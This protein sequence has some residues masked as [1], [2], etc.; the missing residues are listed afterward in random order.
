MTPKLLQKIKDITV[1]NTE[2]DD[3]EILYQLK[4]IIRAEY[5]HRSTASMPISELISRK[6]KKRFSRF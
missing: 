1:C 4:Q 5:N 6:I 3:Q 2:M